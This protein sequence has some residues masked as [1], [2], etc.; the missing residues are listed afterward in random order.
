LDY[1]VLGNGISM[2]GKKIQTIVDWIAPSSVWDMQ[3]FLGFANFYRIFIKDYSKI[4]VPLTRLTRKDKFV[5]DEKVEKTFE[6][7]KKAFTSVPILVH[8]D[9][10]KQLFLETDASDFSLGSILFQYGEDG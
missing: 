10:S 1:I 7:L 2:D 6:T 4:T 9:S 3:C 8:A 5:W